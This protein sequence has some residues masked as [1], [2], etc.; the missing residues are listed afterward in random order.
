MVVTFEN[1]DPRLS[2]P[3][4]QFLDALL[5][6]RRREIADRAASKANGS[7]VSVM[8]IMHAYAQTENQT[9]RVAYRAESRARSAE[10]RS[11]LFMSVALAASLGLG[12]ALSLSGSSSPADTDGPFA[13]AVLAVTVLAVAAAV[14]TLLL[15]ARSRRR[16][17][18][19]VADRNPRL[20]PPDERLIILKRWMDLEAKI[21]RLSG[22]VLQK[23][24]PDP[25]PFG[26]VVDSLVLR[27]ALSADSEFRIKRLLKVRNELAHSLDYLPDM[28]VVGYDFQAVERDV[29][30]T[31]KLAQKAWSREAE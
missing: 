27:E 31:M 2:A 8:D 19:D 15:N 23:Q 20:Q 14:A 13:I 21:R 3:A 26:T 5:D 22:L 25:R 24:T 16:T 6:E 12:L 30:E 10:W 18:V 7:E 17:W 29:D 9:R 4:N 28:R 1:D 11:Y